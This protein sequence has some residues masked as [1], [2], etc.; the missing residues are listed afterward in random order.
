MER[1]GGILFALVLVTA[2]AWLVL[3]FA[4]PRIAQDLQYPLTA[5]TAGL[6][7]VATASY[8]IRVILDFEGIAERAQ[9]MASGLEDQLARW[10]SGPKTAAALQR[11]ARHTAEVMLGDVA[12]WRLLAEGRRLTIPG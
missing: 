5:I 1:F 7:A 6:P 4:A 2:V 3:H 9:Q 8:G 10:D 12:A 11:F